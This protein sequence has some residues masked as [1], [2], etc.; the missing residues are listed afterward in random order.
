MDKTVEKRAYLGSIFLNIIAVPVLPSPPSSESNVVVYSN[1][2]LIPGRLWQATLNWGKG[3]SLC[4]GILL[5]ILLLR[6]KVNMMEKTFSTSF[7]QDC[8]YE[9]YVGL[10]TRFEVAW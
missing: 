5:E 7:V 9:E 4:K 3:F 10:S 2:S 6:R 1:E 8:R